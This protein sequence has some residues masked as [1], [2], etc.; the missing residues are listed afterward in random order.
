MKKIKFTINGIHCKS[1]GIL[2]QDIVS[3]L[4]GVKSVHIGQG[5]KPDVAI[6]DIEFDE[7]NTDANEIKKEI[8]HNGYTVLIQG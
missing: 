6:A 4:D 8:T 1:C 3:D 5:D 2:I 7:S